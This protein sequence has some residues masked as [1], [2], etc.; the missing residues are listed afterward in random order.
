MSVP[1][2]P[3][4]PPEAATPPSIEAPPG[5]W[6]RRPALAWLVV[7]VIA[8]SA[9][10][11][12]THFAWTTS[13]PVSSFV[14]PRSGQGFGGQF[15]GRVPR[16]GP[17]TTPSAPGSAPA[18]SGASAAV[19]A[20]IDRDLVDINTTLA[21]D[22]GEA[23]GTGMVVTSSGEVITNN[24]VIDGA[25]QITARDIGNGKTY[26][27]RVVGYYPGAD[28]AVLAL[29]DAS[30]LAT[31]P[32]GDSSTV[33]VGAG[34]VTIGNAGGAGGTPSV[35]GG[36]VVAQDQ[37]ITAG[38]DADGSSEHLTGLIEIDGELQP[39]DS[40]G[41]LVDS[42]GRVVGMDTAASSGF[43]FRTAAD[44]GFAIPINTVLTVSKQIVAGAGSDAVHIGASAMIGVLV[45]A[46]DDP[47]CYGGYGPPSG[48]GSAVS[49]VAVAQ[50]VP[51]SPAAHA[52]I[53]A[54]DAITALNGQAVNTGEALMALMIR[55]HPGDQVRVSWVDGTGSSHTATVRLATGPAA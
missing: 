48:S 51:G 55:H 11:V 36:S 53:A 31:V 44:Q 14:G 35:A 40:G 16:S 4:P 39:G 46:G 49:G 8:A 15:G 47:S 21:D 1:E 9:G 17:G 19:A 32:M 6:S 22:A 20:R 18:A 10:A 5:A 42:S 23:A 3:T 30:G 43:T 50:A 27:A 54:G 45:C 13:S 12:F 37:S 33:H 24:H 41:P 38:D 52:G 28:V 29:E 7:A 2:S 34:V 26:T 25:V